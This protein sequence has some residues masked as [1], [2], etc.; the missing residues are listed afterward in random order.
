MFKLY[1]AVGFMNFIVLKKKLQFRSFCAAVISV[2]HWRVT[3]KNSTLHSWETSHIFSRSFYKHYKN[4]N[5]KL[6]QTLKW[7]YINI[8]VDE[9]LNENE[10]CSADSVGFTHVNRDGKFS[11]TIF[12]KSAI[13]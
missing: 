1:S 3:T 11:C 6:A 12:I 5:K 10:T 8:I 13:I 9:I 2:Y 7:Q 4:N